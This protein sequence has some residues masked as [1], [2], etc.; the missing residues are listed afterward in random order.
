MSAHARCASVEDPHV[1]ASSRTPPLERR[2]E[3]TVS[4]AEPEASGLRVRYLTRRGARELSE[5]IELWPP[6]S[7]QAVNGVG[8][9]LRLLRAGRIAAPSEPYTLGL[10]LDEAAR[11][12]ER[13]RG[14][15]VVLRVRRRLQRELTLW[16]DTGVERIERVLDYSEDAE[17]LTVRRLG[18]RSMLRIPREG[19]IRFQA[20]SSESLEVLSVEV[21]PR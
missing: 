20:S 6:G 1:V 9:L 5:F 14:A 3:A 15:C 16:T 12:I 2:L 7:L 17:G 4:G 13:C 18:G 10:D 19:M 11:W 8:R 21:P